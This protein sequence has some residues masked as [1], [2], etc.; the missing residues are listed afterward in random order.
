MH[1]SVHSEVILEKE[2][3]LLSGL[4]ALIDWISQIEIVFTL[5]FHSPEVMT[6]VR[7]LFF[8]FFILFF[9]RK[10]GSVLDKSFS[11]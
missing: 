6:F 2:M 7:E 3:P 4:F 8:F 11:P 1:C 10:V 5:C 9:S